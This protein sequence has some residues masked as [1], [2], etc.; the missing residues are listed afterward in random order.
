ME[1]SRRKSKPSW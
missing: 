1:E